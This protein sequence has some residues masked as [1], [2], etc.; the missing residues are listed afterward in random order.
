MV[1]GTYVLTDT[2]KAGFSGLFTTVYQNADAVI[3][4][5]AATGTPNNNSPGLQPAFSESLLARVRALPDV[6]D[7]GGNVAYPTFLVGRDNKVIAAF[8]G[9][10]LGFGIDPK[11]ANDS[12]NPLKIVAGTWPVDSSQIAIDTHTASSHHYSV[13]QTIGA[14][15]GDQVGHYRIVGTVKL[16]QASIGGTTLAVFDLKTGQ[17]LFHKEGKLDAIDVASKAGVAPT[18]LVQ[19]IRPLLPATAEVRTGTAQAAKD[20]SDTSTFTT[21]IQDFLLAFAGIA[22]FVGSFVIANTLSITIAQRT[23]EFATLRTLGATRRQ[24]MRSVLVEAFVIG[25]LASAVG[26]G[27][28]LALAKLLNALFVSFGIDLPKA[29]TVFK[30][31]TIVVSL[32]LGT[33][34]TV[35]ASLRPARRATR[36]EP[37][38]AVREGAVLPPSRL[39]RFG[40]PFALATFVVG[41]ALLLYG[42][43]A[44]G[45]STKARLFAIGGG[46]LLLFFGVALLAPRLVPPLAR[47]LGRPGAEVGGVAGSLAQQNSMRNPARTAAT[48]SALMIG[49]ALVTVV[50]VLAAGLKTRFESSVNEL[51]VADYA[52]TSQN[53]FIP[54]GIASANALKHVPGVQVVSAV[55]AGDGR[56]L[57]HHVNI[58]AVDPQVTKVIS[59]KWTDGSDA[60]PGKLGARG[61]IVAKSY[62]KDHHLQVGSPIPLL[63][64]SGKTLPLRLA[65]IFDPPKGGSPFGDITIST[66]T[67]DRNY[68][69][70]TNLFSFIRVAGGVTSANTQRLN[71]ALKSFPDAKLQTESQFKKNQERGID[72]LLNLL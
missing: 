40:L 9:G 50:A 62:A 26:L 55:R 36:V 10:G 17:A 38:A 34:V 21:V 72:V 46:V 33:V 64:P 52:L 14:T 45:A 20:T 15:I 70:P 4:G 22:L 13:G 69:N 29:G 39:A 71:A 18:K 6:A 27:L 3:S 44:N 48:A 53:G 12:L 1:S 25:L 19:E 51:F 31:R 43:L 65:G 54:T 42:G 58:T 61:A 11:R 68:A 35:L 59:L 5:K 23:R 57:G 41:L 63:T 28:G 60:T 2:I 7:A 8:G 30:T 49:L 37:I 66:S 32:V 67:F 24:V 56:A 47:V 16:G